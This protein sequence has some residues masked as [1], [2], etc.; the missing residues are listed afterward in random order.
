MVAQGGVDWRRT[1]FA[2]Q[3]IHEAHLEA[4]ANSKRPPPGSF[5]PIDNPA[6]ALN[7][8][9]QARSDDGLCEAVLVDEQMLM[10]KDGNSFGDKV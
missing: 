4:L 5:D 9:I 7:Q 8:S 2:Y 10:T 1:R 3:K 6:L